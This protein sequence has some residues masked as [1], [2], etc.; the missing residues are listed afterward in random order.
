MNALKDTLRTHW[1]LLLIIAILA[2]AIGFI[3]RSPSTDHAHDERAATE[4]ATWTCSMHPQIRQPDPGKCPI[5]AMDLIP[6]VEDEGAADLGE[7]QLKLSPAAMKLADVQTSP[8][9]RKN[10]AKNIA[11]YGKIAVDETRTK[12]IT[13]WAP[14]R[15]E[16]LHVDYTGATVRA[17][18]PLVDIY[19]PELFVAQ[20]EYLNAL[21]NS[22]SALLNIEDVRQKFKLWGIT[23]AQLEQIEQRGHA[24]ENMTIYAPISGIVLN[25]AINQGKYVQT[26]TLLYD[27]AD[28]SSVWIYLNAYEKDLPWLREG[29]RFSFTAEALPGQSFNGQIDFIDPVL[30]RQSRTVKVRAVAANPGNK[31]KP[32]L[33]VTADIKAGT[34]EAASLA[35]PASAPLITGERAVVYVSVPGGEGVFEGREI[36]LGERADDYFIVKEG[37]RSGEMVVTNG[38]FKIDSEMQIRAKQSMMSPEGKSM[39]MGHQH[40]EEMDMQATSAQ[41]QDMTGQPANDAEE[42]MRSEMPQDM[43]FSAEFVASL[44]PVYLNYFEIQ[45]DL[46]HDKAD[47]LEKTAQALLN[48]LENVQAGELGAHAEHWSRL[49]SRIESATRNIAASDNIG[50]IRSEFKKLSDALIETASMFGISDNIEVKQYHCPMA[51]NDAGA[52]W[53]SPKDEVENP[54]FGAEMFNCGWRVKTFGE[55]GGDQE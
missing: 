1:K 2:F 36:L 43:E 47:N 44:D 29:Q 10:V 7:R 4:E 34:A 54:Y 53:L 49:S 8:V 31:L 51:F 23:E 45:D 24:V 55:N 41:K 15:I 37:L 48:G 11:L 17:N 20:Q 50:I 42:R 14:G 25:K 26:G 30:D 35:I 52:D 32:G 6:I 12:S 5:C 3:S 27:I 22:G 21:S 38:A 40:G 18:E 9:E 33:L 46:A 13:A 28:F 39:P 19:S 16:K